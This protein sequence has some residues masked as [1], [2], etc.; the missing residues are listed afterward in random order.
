[1]LTYDEAAAAD[2][3]ARGAVRDRDHRRPR[4]AGE[5][6]QARAAEPAGDLRNS[7][8][9]RRR[10]LPRLRGRALELRRGD[11]A[12][13]RAWPPC[14]STATAWRRATG[15]PS[16]CAT[17]PSG[18]SPSPPSPRSGAVSVSLNAWW[19]ADELDYAL[20]DCGA[21]RARSPTPSGSSAGT[22]R[23]ARLGCRI[24]AV[25]APGDA[26]RAA[27]TAGRTC[28]APGAPLP[29]VDV[30]PDDDATILYTSGTTGPPEGRGVDPPRG[31]AGA[32]GVRLPGRGRAPAPARGGPRPTRRRL[33]PAFILIV[34]LFHVTGCVPVMLVVLR[35]R[36]EA[37]DHVQVGRRAGPRADRAG[38]GHQ[39]RRR[40][41]PELGPA[42]VAAVRRLSTRRAWR[43]SAAA[44]RR[45]RPSW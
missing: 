34:P 45:P 24:L 37:R 1:M 33:P 29:D 20:E 42:R 16:P 17:T 13:R 31:R 7:L 9:P 8:G 11:G 4:R 21:T 39:L 3:R 12:R 38:A 6:V 18:S 15:S 32:D 25:R 26:A 22:P 35:Q 30:D 2:H 36:A 19:T 40:A 23:A 44:A 41:H 43:A 14:S 28:V 27:S 5:G 10:D